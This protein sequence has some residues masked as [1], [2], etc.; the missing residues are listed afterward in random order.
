M[1]KELLIPGTK[2]G[3]I[4]G[5]G[6]ET[7]KQ[8]QEK[9]GVKIILIQETQSAGM[10]PKPL[11]IMGDVDKVEYAKSLVEEIMNSKD[12]LPPGPRQ[13][14]VH[15]DYGSSAKS[16]GE[17]IVPRSSVGMIIGK[18]GEMIRKLSQDSGAKIQFKQDEDQN[19]MERTAIIQGTPDQIQRATHM[20]S[21]LVNK[22]GEGGSDVFY[23]HIPSTKT[24]LVIGRGGETIKQIC[25]ESGAHVELSRDAP[26]S[27]TEK[28]FI[29]KGTPYQIHHAQH[30]IRIKVGDIAP[31]T[32][33]PPYTGPG[34]PQQGGGDQQ[35]GAYPNPAAGQF[36]QPQQ[37][38]AGYQQQADPNAWSNYYQQQQQFGNFY[39]G[40]GAAPAAP[41]P[42]PQPQPAV[43]PQPTAQAAPAI[44][45]QTGQPDYSAQWAEYYR[46]LGMH[47]QA[48][49][50]E[51]QA[52][53]NQAAAASVQ[54]PVAPQPQPTY[55]AGYGQQQPAAPYPTAGYG[56]P[57]P[58]QQGYPQY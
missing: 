41:Q 14:F 5:K 11:R 7:I 27:A 18:G 1:T 21:D 12:D 19:G 57:Q 44:N 29:I 16:I 17:V 48:A 55:T 3:L 30:I 42:Q 51:Q 23:M 10:A 25:A 26:P 20:I 9:A 54:Q 38:G 8:I 13:N 45:P 35:W 36:G 53:A 58:A 40:Q 39:G 31:G 4:I 47:D 34:G 28:V 24:G 22:S 49:M 32:P 37:W 2:C 6:G 43:A 15:N 46:S 52:K 33:V 56:A 50:I